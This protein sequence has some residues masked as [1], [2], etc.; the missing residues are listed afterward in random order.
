M[1]TVAGIVCYSNKSANDFQVYTNQG[2]FYANANDFDFETNEHDRLYWGHAVTLTK[3][4]EQRE[5]R[6]YTDN[7]VEYHSLPKAIRVNR[8]TGTNAQLQRPLLHG[9]VIGPY[10]S[11]KNPR[12]KKSMTTIEIAIPQTELPPK[13]FQVQVSNGQLKDSKTR[14]P[15]TKLRF[16]IYQNKARWNILS[17][18]SI[19]DTNNAAAAAMNDTDNYTLPNTFMHDISTKGK[20]GIKTDLIIGEIENDILPCITLADWANMKKNDLHEAARYAVTKYKKMKELAHKQH[21]L[22]S[23]TLE[24]MKNAKKD[25]S[26]EKE[27]ELTKKLHDV[28]KEHTRCGT[29]ES[30]LTAACKKGIHITINPRWQNMDMLEWGRVIDASKSTNEDNVN[31]TDIDMIHRSHPNTTSESFYALNGLPIRRQMLEGIEVCMIPV[32]LGTW[33]KAKKEFEYRKTTGQFALSLLVFDTARARTLLGSALPPV[34]VFLPR[35]YEKE[36]QKEAEKELQG[37][38]LLESFSMCDALS[39]MD[40][41][42]YLIS[43][44]AEESDHA[45]DNVLNDKSN[46]FHYDEYAH[47]PH[48]SNFW[49]ASVSTNELDEEPHDYLKKLLSIADDMTNYMTCM[50][51]YD[52][53]GLGGEDRRFFSIHPSHFKTVISHLK[54]TK[55]VKFMLPLNNNTICIIPNQASDMTDIKQ[56]IMTTNRGYIAGEKPTPYK[57]EIL[58]SQDSHKWEFHPFVERASRARSPGTNTVTNHSHRQWLPYV[59][60]KGLMPGTPPQDVEKAIAALSIPLSN[61]HININKQNVDWVSGGKKGCALRVGTT[62]IPELGDKIIELKAPM[63]KHPLTIMSLHQFNIKACKG[64]AITPRRSGR[65]DPEQKQ[66]E[67]TPPPKLRKAAP[68]PPEARRSITD[69]RAADAAKIRNILT[70]PPPRQPK[71][72]QYN[73][74]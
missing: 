37:F 9:T 68:L 13:K 59:I 73:N 46:D 11:V 49:Y 16:H 8:D 48:A 28:K 65:K 52:A 64:S 14:I 20:S 6:W 2:T 56:A 55:R 27:E 38:E 47:I 24:R 7:E 31:I 54:E 57:G 39:K 15:G 1:N 34:G 22:F 45:C 33:C 10:D 25:D 29:F 51:M 62:T 23:K 5:I 53:M 43:L 66:Q 30:R 40:D 72:S 12:L 18:V 36:V 21:Q 70:T 71:A 42:H 4:D 3:S 69:L 19:A 58:F 50:P 63:Y 17:R 41:H 32:T 26:K 44:P 60:I 61:M 67:A 35:N 74:N